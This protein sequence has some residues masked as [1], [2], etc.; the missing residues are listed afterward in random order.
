MCYIP[1]C[2]IRRLLMRCCSTR[3]ETAGSA[4]SSIF[5][6]AVLACVLASL[7]G[8]AGGSGGEFSFGADVLGTDS[9]GG[10]A[11]GVSAEGTGY[12]GIGG[13]VVGTGV[14]LA[15]GGTIG[16]VCGGVATGLGTGS[17]AAGGTIGGV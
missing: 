1:K 5:G 7:G 15:A 11:T 13:A 3:L 10:V 6:F 8:V 14:L 12:G 16:N 4:G 17:D 2:Y 9:F